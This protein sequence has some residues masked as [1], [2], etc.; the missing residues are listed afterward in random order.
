MEIKK[1]N[2]LEEV[3]ALF[4]AVKLEGLFE[5]LDE[6]YHK[7]PGISQ[8]MIKLYLQVPKKLE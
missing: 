3:H 8:S 2:T 4:D 5:I 1:L 6:V 7:S